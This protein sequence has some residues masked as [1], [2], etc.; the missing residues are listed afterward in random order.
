MLTSLF[1]CS[2]ANSQMNT[3]QTHSTKSP[4]GD[5]AHEEDTVKSWTSTGEPGNYD[6]GFLNSLVWK[7]YTVGTY[8]I[9]TGIIFKKWIA[10]VQFVK[11]GKLVLTEYTPPSE[12]VT[13]VD[14]ITARDE[15]EPVAKDANNDGILEIVFLHRKLSDA[16][17]HMYAV[18]ALEKNAPK[19]IWKSAGR[20]GDWVNQSNK[21]VR[22]GP[23]IKIDTNQK[24]DR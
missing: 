7:D 10:A 20:L 13:F 9:R 22:T 14:P 3:G 19:L 8:V 1:V 12:Y 6:K 23:L 16:R 2:S 11:D 5:S 4:G 18:Y 17:Y 21:G 24:L 15:K